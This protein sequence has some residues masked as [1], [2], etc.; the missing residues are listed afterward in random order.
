MTGDQSAVDPFGGILDAYIAPSLVWQFKEGFLSSSSESGSEPKFESTESMESK[1][2]SSS[3]ESE[4]GIPGVDNL[5]ATVLS[6]LSFSFS[7]ESVVTEESDE[8]NVVNENGIAAGPS[9]YQH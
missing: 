4:S 6:R 2:N 3:F 5:D 9:Q 1:S 8:L 7:F